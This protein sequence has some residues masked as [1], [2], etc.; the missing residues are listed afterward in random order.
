MSLTLKHVI[1]AKIKKSPKSLNYVLV[2]D[3]KH[4]LIMIPTKSRQ[5]GWINSSLK[6]HRQQIHTEYALTSNL[7]T[8]NAV[9]LTP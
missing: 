8:F 4:S 2:T 6:A 3:C 7:K 1:L 9:P 5:I